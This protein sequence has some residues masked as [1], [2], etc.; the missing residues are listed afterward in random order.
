MSRTSALTAGQESIAF[1]EQSQ[2]VLLIKEK[3]KMVLGLVVM[4]ED[5]RILILP[6]NVFME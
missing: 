3:N 2:G 4:S 5:T 6:L 1:R